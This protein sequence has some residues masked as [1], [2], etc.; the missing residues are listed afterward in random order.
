MGSASTMPAEYCVARNFTEAPCP[1]PLVP[2][3]S[4]PPFLPPSLAPSGVHA[5]RTER[6]G[7]GRDGRRRKGE[8]SG[9]R[10]CA[11]HEF[12]GSR[13]PKPTPAAV[14]TAVPV[15]GWRGRLNG[16]RAAVAAT[17]GCWDDCWKRRAP[18]RRVLPGAADAGGEV[19]TGGGAAGVEV[20]VRGRLGWGEVSAPEEGG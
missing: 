6:D 9:P 19:T 1:L 10:A 18:R 2:L 17:G 4:F 11:Y 13:T 20:A 16:T 12:L 14:A 8:T 15:A 5:T 3:S 7:W